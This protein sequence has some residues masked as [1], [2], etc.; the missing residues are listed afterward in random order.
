MKVT[1]ND[2]AQLLA[3]APPRQVPAPVAKAVGG[4]RASWFLPLF[5]VVFGGM[6]LMF[7]V[8][9]FPWR[10]RDDWQLAADGARTVQGLITEVTK[11][12][13]SIND[14]HVM[15]YGFR[16]TPEDG[17]PRQG[18]CFTSGER[19]TNNAPVAVRYLPANP[20]LACVEGARLSEGGGVGSFVLVFPLIGGG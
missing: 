2:V 18:R 7:S 12:G 5:G 20:D 8:M 3:S 13:M 11:T 15:E 16:Y 19:W 10:F 9:F 14:V 6:G 4:G 1:A 17:R